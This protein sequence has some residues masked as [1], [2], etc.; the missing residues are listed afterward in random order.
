MDRKLLEAPVGR[1][2]ARYL[3]PTVCATLVTAVYL[4]ADTVMVGYRLGAEGVAALNLIV[5]LEFGFFAVGSLLGNGGGICFTRRLSLGDAVGARRRFATAA[6]L[7]AAFAVA[8]TALSLLF[9]RPLAAHV[10]GA[11][12]GALLE[13]AVEYGVFIAAG[14]PVFVAVTLLAPLLRHDRAPRRA[15]AGVL[16]GGLANIALDWFFLYPL[17]WGLA[18]AGLST[19]LGAA[20]SAVI[21]LTHFRW[22]GRGLR[23]ARPSWRLAPEVV[24]FGGGDCL[25]ELAGCVSV[26]LFNRLTMAFLGEDG[27]VVYG[28]VANYLLAMTALFNGVAQAAHPLTAANAAAGRPARARRVVA[29]ALRVAGGA[30]AAA[31]LGALAAPGAFLRAFLPA[32]EVAALPA[33][34][35]GALATALLCLP[36]MGAA[37]IATLQLPALGRPGLGSAFAFLR[38]GALLAAFGWALGWAVGPWGV[39][40]AFAAAEAAVLPGLLLALRGWGGAPGGRSGKGAVA[41]G[42]EGEVV[43]GDVGAAEDDV[44]AEGHAEHLPGAD[45][46]A[47]GLDVLRA[48]GDVA[49]GVV[50]GDDDA[51]GA[52]EKGA[53]EDGGDVDE[54]LAAQA[55]G[56]ER[57]LAADEGAAVVE[58]Q[59]PETLA[60]AAGLLAEEV[61]RGVGGGED[62]L[63]ERAGRG[64]ED[65]GAELQGGE[66]GGDL[67]VA[68]AAEPVGVLADV[69]AELGVAVVAQGGEALD[70]EALDEGLGDLGDVAALDAGAQED[71][72]ELGVGHRLAAEAEEPLAGAVVGGEV[73]H[74]RGGG[75]RGRRLG[76]H[77]R[78]SQAARTRPA[79]ASTPSPS[80]AWTQATSN[81]VRRKDS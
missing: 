56:E 40:W 8:A 38:G 29:L 23:W 4:F 15:M 67:V 54:R 79:R 45:E 68:D 2:F 50:V 1:L 3:F 55:G 17:G 26:M 39:W 11:G 33:A 27:L 63:R 57:G 35:T 21:M 43:R 66:E 48:G 71:G 36:L 34:A 20:L 73:G 32:G 76:G 12:E 60:H 49:G 58:G 65:A 78:A 46:G 53:L 51:G 44:V 47:G 41:A 72:H 13:A 9:L 25:Q 77:G 81:C 69:G 74:P 42:A 37:Q 28:V 30:G 59:Q 14:C 22:P 24:G 64:A 75:R 70:V 7:G 18:G 62:G 80:A 31:A 10:L 6:A 61:A 52:E 5:P 19:A 16:A